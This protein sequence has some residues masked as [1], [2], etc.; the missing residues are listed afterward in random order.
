MRPTL[1][2]AT[3]MLLLLAPTA[4]AG[5]AENPEITDGSGDAGAGAAWGDVTAAWWNETATDIVVTIQL[6]QLTPATP[7]DYL[8]Y[9]IM[10]AGSGDNRTFGCYAFI[11]NGQPQFGCSHWD[12]TT[13]PQD[14][15]DG[16]GALSP[17][18]PGTVT[19]N[20]PKLVANATA[21]MVLSMLSVGSGTAAF[22]DVPPPIGP[23]GSFVPDDAAQ[24][25]GTYTI[26]AGGSGAPAPAPNATQPGGN[27]TAPGNGTGGG[28]ATQP[29]A[30]Q[31]AQPQR[32]PALGAMAFVA[33]A[34]AAALAARRR[35]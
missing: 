8:W 9:D 12:R 20:L 27:T 26:A 28:N 7:E 21:G 3:A 4:M 31:G 1:P 15:L 16:T 19:L 35:R 33:A 29:P 22:V 17:G 11:A 24:G 23:V 32:T 25:S 6:A 5:D 18:Q 34:G 13:G 2:M 14:Q 10:D 30:D